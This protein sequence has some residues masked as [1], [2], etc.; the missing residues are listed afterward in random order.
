MRFW[1]NRFGAI[2]AAE[3]RWRRVAAMRHGRHGRG[4]LDEFFVK[5][6]GVKHSLSRAVDH[7]GEGLESCVKKRRDKKAAL[8]V[9]RKSLRRHGGTE[10]IVTDR[11]A[12]CRAVLSFGRGWQGRDG[13]LAVQPGGEQPAAFP[14]TGTGDAPLPADAKSAEV[15]RVAPLYPQSL[16]LGTHP[17]Q[18]ADIQGSPNRRSGRVAAPLRGLRNAGVG[19]FLRL[20]SLL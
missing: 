2:F 7:E 16:Q 3:I 12:S 6:N 8:K 9:L 15:C 4:N 1:W 11:L 13:A 17:R 19:R 18:Q 14:T 5:I 20:F 10:A